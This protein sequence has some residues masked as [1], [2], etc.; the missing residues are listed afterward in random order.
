MIGVPVYLCQPGLLWRRS[1][2][3]RHHGYELLQGMTASERLQ[4]ATRI[5]GS[6]SIRADVATLCT[7]QAPSLKYGSGKSSLVEC[8]S[9]QFSTAVGGS[10]WIMLGVRQPHCRANNVMLTVSCPNWTTCMA[11]RAGRPCRPD[12]GTAESSLTRSV[13][14]ITGLGKVQL[15][16]TSYARLAHFKWGDSATDRIHLRNATATMFRSETRCPH[17][18]SSHARDPDFSS[19]H[20][21]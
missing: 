15:W 21:S 14:A 1:D 13:N 16:S 11:R 7:A 10:S 20:S 9:R 2:F 12:T 4:L 18:D 6:R 8:C 19:S 17:N 3:R 5:L